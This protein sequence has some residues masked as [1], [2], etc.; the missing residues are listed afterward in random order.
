M[1]KSKSCYLMV[2]S[3]SVLLALAGLSA[4]AFW[5]TP[6]I[7]MQSQV[8]ATADNPNEPLQNIK[9]TVYDVGIY[10]QE[11]QVNAGRLGIVFD[12]RTGMSPGF[13]VQRITENSTQ[14]VTQINAVTNHSRTRGQVKLTPGCYHVFDSVRPQMYSTLI[15]SPQN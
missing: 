2:A 7:L 9:F 14:L 4:A 3:L 5:R 8:S 1:S 13:V 6:K 15:V 11:M 12:D 10:P